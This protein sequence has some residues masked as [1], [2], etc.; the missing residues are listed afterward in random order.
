MPVAIVSERVVQDLKLANP[1]GS[2]L[3][4]GDTDYEIV[5][6]A[7]NAL[8]SRLTQPTA[9]TYLPML[10]GTR[11]ATVLLR[12]TIKPAAMTGA[13]REAV[14]SVDAGV[15]LVDVFTM[16]QQ[17]SRTLQRERMF[18]WLCGSFGVL[19]LVLCVVGLYGLMSHA[20]AR[21]TPEI[22]IRMALGASSRQVMRQVVSE[23]MS[24]AVAGLIAGIPLAVYAAKFAQKLRM[25]PAGPIPYWTLAAALA[26]LLLSTFVAVLGPALRASAVEPMR[27]LRQG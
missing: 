11:T 9:V 6:V 8:Y 2:R 25:L 15:P 23:G 12:T 14:R 7:R 24:L 13:A 10:K 21:R 22:G 16:E 26:V 18:A 17:I 3:K 5:G 1:L 4:T 19:A 20:T 27:A